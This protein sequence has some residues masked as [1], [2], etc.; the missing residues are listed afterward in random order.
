[1]KYILQFHQQTLFS[2]YNTSHFK[3]IPFLH[4]FYQSKT[5]Q[6]FGNCI[7]IESNINIYNH[8]VRQTC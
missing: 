5:S 8:E 4:R 2:A 3:Y 1:M 6:A 7:E